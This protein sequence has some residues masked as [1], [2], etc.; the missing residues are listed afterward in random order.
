MIQRWSDHVLGSNAWDLSSSLVRS[1][2][3]HSDLLTLVL[4]GIWRGSNE[5]KCFSN[6]TGLPLQHALIQIWRPL[7]FREIWM[8]S[9]GCGSLSSFS[10]ANQLLHLTSV[11]LLPIQ[12]LSGFS[13]EIRWLSVSFLSFLRIQERYSSWAYSPQ[14]LKGFR[15]LLS[16]THLSEPSIF[17]VVLKPSSLLYLPSMTSLRY[18][19]NIF[20]H[21]LTCKSLC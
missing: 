4:S 2:C 13:S 8:R 20:Q 5:H 6:L 14:F 9:C 3:L 12:Q 11:Q 10:C 17:T 16:I 19:L 21:Y 18:L 1:S 7:F 15:R